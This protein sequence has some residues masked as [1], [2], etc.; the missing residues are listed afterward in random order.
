[1]N[2]L[3]SVI[4]PCYNQAQYLPDALQSLLGQDYPHWE[5][6]IVNDGSPD[7][8]EETAL[9]WTS[10]DCRIKYFYKENSGVC[11]T[12]NY[13]IR[14]AI[15]EFIVPLDSD[16]KLSP[17]YFSEAIAVFKKHPDVKLVYSDII[18]FG[19]K[20]EEI[21]NKDFVFENMITENQISN[22]AVFRRSDF[23]TAGGYNA[24][25]VYG[26]EDWDFY[27]SLLKPTDKV[28]KLKA[29]HQYYRI[30]AVS[31]SANVNT[32]RE[33]NDAMLLQMFKNH[34]PLFLEYLNPIRNKIE[35]DYYKKEVQTYQNSKEY[36]L[37]RVILSPFR[38]LQKVCR[39]LFS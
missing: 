14:Q 34:V 38:L 7:N 11:D 24:N 17:H 15:G 1:M 35:A 19:D 21:I 32:H 39:R 2:P 36:K 27:L 33:K 28:I 30:R 12:R 6:I 16:D 26:I 29:F 37:G 20:N 23:Q 4:V 8:T 31:R 10:K 18:L 22:S 9:Q 25:M 5:C 13:G 3:I